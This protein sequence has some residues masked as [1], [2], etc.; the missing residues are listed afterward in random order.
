MRKTF[1]IAATVAAAAALAVAGVALA[2]SGSKAKKTGATGTATR[3]ARTP[4]TPLTGDTKTK[5]EA[6]A[7]AAVAGTVE[8]STTAH[9]PISGAA[10][11]VRV[12]KADGT[13]VLVVLDSSFEVLQTLA[14]GP[15]GRPGGRHDGETPLTGDTKTKAEAAAKAAVPGGTVDFSS[16]ETGG[17]N[18]A[19][20]YEVHV[21]KSD[22]THVEVLLDGDFAVLSVEAHA[23]RPGGAPPG[24][25]PPGGTR[26]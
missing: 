21:T 9:A 13:H 17:G 18:S 4:E 15:H 24:G 10:Y 26:H 25:M 14:G 11:E 2:G 20:K 6:A 12:A 22:G 8:A 5:A 3:P 19:A 1:T 7:T 23:G 16:T